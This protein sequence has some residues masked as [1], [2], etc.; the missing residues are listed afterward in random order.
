LNKINDAR[1]VVTNLIFPAI[2]IVKGDVIRFEMKEVMFTANAKIPFPNKS[3]K[4]L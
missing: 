4:I 1:I 2:D 3:N